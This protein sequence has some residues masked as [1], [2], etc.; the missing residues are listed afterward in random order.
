MTG[1][2]V[3]E[4]TESGGIVNGYYLDFNSYNEYAGYMGWVGYDLYPGNIWSKYRDGV[5]YIPDFAEWK[6]GAWGIFYFSEITVVN[7]DKICIGDTY[8]YRVKKILNKSSVFIENS[9]VLPKVENIC[10]IIKNSAFKAFCYKHFDG[11]GDGKVS[12]EEA[13]VY[14]SISVSDERITSM[15]GI[16][17]FVNLKELSCVSCRLT[18]LDVNNNLNLSSLFI[19]NNHVCPVKV[20]DGLYKV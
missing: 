16:E 14:K 12:M 4:D 3:Q 20:P 18:S 9:N 11:N 8:F 10:T 13:A 5:L 15:K 7:K 19:M 2:W 6:K 1:C 17:Y